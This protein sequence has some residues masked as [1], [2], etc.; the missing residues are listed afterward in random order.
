MIYSGRIS[1]SKGQP[2]PGAS[3]SFT[4]D[5]GQVIATLPVSAAGTFS[6][7][8]SFDDGLFQ[9]GIAAIFSAPGYQYFSIDS[10]LMP[11]VFNVTLKKKINQ[12]LILGI[13]A[14]TALI[15][16]MSGKKKLSGFV[17][18]LPPWAKG[19]ALVGGI[20]VVYYFLLKGKNESGLLPQTADSELSKLMAQGQ[21]PT[22]S[23]AQAEILSSKIVA[24]VDDCGTDENAIYSAF[25]N[26]NN[27]ADL[28]LLA[29]T[30][31][32]RT[33]KG[34]GEAYFG[35]VHNNLSQTLTDELSS[36]EIDTLNNI[37]VQ[38]GIN[39]KF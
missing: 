11:Q 28:M 17:S 2:V 6:V 38:E 14:G 1:D 35:Y 22:I 4:N 37:L 32:V 27:T 24:A 39:Y 20:G 9:S 18:D 26:L 7:D 30:Y 36:S 16:A 12:D 31:G 13:G 33:Y 5:A 21:F 34:C 25:A 15:L 10:T 29:K 3:L 23:A 19:L 8:T